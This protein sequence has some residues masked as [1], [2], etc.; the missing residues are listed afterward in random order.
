MNPLYLV[1]HGETY[2]NVDDPQWPGVQMRGLSGITLTPHGLDEAAQAAATLQGRGAVQILCSNT[3]RTLQTARIIADR[4]GLPVG[5]DRNLDTWDV[6]DLTG[7][8]EADPKNWALLEQFQNEQPDDTL[9]GSHETFHQFLNRVEQTLAH[10]E[11]MAQMLGPLILVTHG[12]LLFSAAHVR[13]NR[14]LDIEDDGP[15]PGSVVA[16]WPGE[17]HY[18][19]VPARVVQKAAAPVIPDPLL[20]LADKLAP[21]IRQAFLAAIRTVRDQISLRALTQ[22]VETGDVSAVRA[23]GVWDAFLDAFE[24]RIRQAVTE[25]ILGGANHAASSLPSS[26]QSQLRFDLGN[27]RVVQAVDDVVVPMLQQIA[28]VN[29]QG[30]ATA[31]RRGLSEGV[32]PSALARKLIWEL[33]LTDRDIT[34]VE[35]YLAGLVKN[36]MPAGRAADLAESYANRLLRQRASLIAR[37]ETIRAVNAGQ[38]AAWQDAK[39]QGLLTDERRFWVVTPDDRLCPL[40]EVMPD[41]NAEGRAFDEPFQS[42]L[43]PVT[44]PP[45]HPACRCTT[46]LRSPR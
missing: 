1:R 27:P 22:A 12:R 44:G 36:D 4:L 35:N 41:Q 31:L 19:A 5:Q 37:T 18:R 23:T 16:L 24:P 39:D 34:A 8:D 26:V 32:S 17:P 21:D 33:G 2:F 6:G 15:P 14:T 28:N 42:E 20:A 3:V 30:L 40:C 38:T 43:G 7:K 11:A 13:S 29:Q 45:L 10:Y 46:V 25:A 9:P